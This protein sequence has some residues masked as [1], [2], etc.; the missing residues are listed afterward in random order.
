MLL[1]EIATTGPN[2]FYLAPWLVFFPVIGLLTNIIFGKRMSEK[3]IGGVAS[4]ASGMTFVVAL[5]LVF[6]LR[7]HPEG[8]TIVLADWITIGEL[9]LRWAFRVDTLSTTMMM[10]V[11]VV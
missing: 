9:N 11:G 1:S 2:F 10:V 4:L 3:A 7:S 6:S 8:T 5:L